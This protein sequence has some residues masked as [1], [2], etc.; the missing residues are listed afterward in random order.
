MDSLL[1]DV[2]NSSMGTFGYICEAQ[3]VKKND[4]TMV[5]KSKKEGSKI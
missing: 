5:K 3:I 2:S 4:N 1:R